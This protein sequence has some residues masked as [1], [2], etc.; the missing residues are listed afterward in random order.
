MHINNKLSE[1]G[2]VSFEL[3]NQK[4]PASEHR[5]I[6]ESIGRLDFMRRKK[7]PSI[8]DSIEKS[9]PMVIIRKIED[10]YENSEYI[11]DLLKIQA[12]YKDGL[13]VALNN[14]KVK[15]FLFN[16]LNY[17]YFKEIIEISLNSN[18]SYFLNNKELLS[19]FQDL[20]ILAV[21]KMIENSPEDYFYSE[22][23]SKYPELRDKAIDILRISDPDYLD[24]IL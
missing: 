21:E 6:L 3:S 1:D 23:E 18:P 10:L 5:K 7:D 13:S 17:D 9:R 8:R 22:Y 24:M 2:K 16:E 14:E 20:E 15:D 11:I 19:K 12:S 4:Q